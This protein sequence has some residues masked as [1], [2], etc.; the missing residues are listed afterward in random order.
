LVGGGRLLEDVATKGGELEQM[1]ERGRVERRLGWFGNG[2][3]EKKKQKEKQQREEAAVL[4]DESCLYTYDSPSPHIAADQGHKEG[5]GHI[6][7]ASTGG[8]TLRPLRSA[9]GCT[10]PRCNTIANDHRLIGGLIKYSLQHHVYN[11]T[12]CV[13]DPCA[14][15]PFIHLGAKK[16]SRAGGQAQRPPQAARKSVLKGAHGG[17]AGLARG[18]GRKKQPGRRLGGQHEGVGQQEGLDEAAAAGVKEVGGKARQASGED[19]IASPPP[20]LGA[21][22][23]ASI[24][25]HEPL[26]MRP[27]ST[28]YHYL[29]SKA[30]SELKARLKRR[31][32]LLRRYLRA[33]SGAMQSRAPL[34]NQERQW[35]EFNAARSRGEQCRAP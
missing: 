20:D 19:W 14:S 9:V 13:Y 30:F 15:M 32:G 21:L 35:A 31:F 3:A 7:G 28:L 26:A 29:H 5:N 24:L 11:S 10:G 34:R 23:E 17:R 25:A 27:G 8:P 4:A 6:G 1:G 18:R 33:C 2:D 12:I 22:L 16:A